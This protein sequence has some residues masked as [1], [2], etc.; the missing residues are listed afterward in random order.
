MVLHLV[1]DE[2]HVLLI[3]PLYSDIRN[4]YIVTHSRCFMP[5]DV[6]FI[7]IM[8]IKKH[9]FINDLAVFI[10]SI[11]CSISMHII[12]VYAHGPDTFNE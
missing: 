3:C 8:S 9:R 12:I 10:L 6:V 5:S 7:Q 11:I 1:E 2:Y 4:K